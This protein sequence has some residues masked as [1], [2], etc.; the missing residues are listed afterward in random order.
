MEDVFTELLKHI[1]EARVVFDN[2]NRLTRYQALYPVFL[3]IGKCMDYMRN[4]EDYTK[5][6]LF[7]ETLYAISYNKQ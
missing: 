5:Y 7:M 4:N 6:C 3:E 2:T 1:A